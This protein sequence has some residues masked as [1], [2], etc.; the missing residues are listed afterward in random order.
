[1][2]FGMPQVSLQRVNPAEWFDRARTRLNASYAA[3][4]RAWE[5][6]MSAMAVA[7]AALGWGMERVSGG[8]SSVIASVLLTITIGFFVEY[9]GRLLAAHDRRAF[10]RDHIVELVAV[11]PWVRLV[12][13]V[14]L[15]WVV[16]GRAAVQH[17]RAWKT[18]PQLIPAGSRGSR[19]G[20]LWAVLL[21]LTAVA[22]Y[23]YVAAA[24][25]A[26]SEGRFALV[27]MLLC[28]FSGLTASLAT[29]FAARGFFPSEVPSRLRT[30]EELKAAKLITTNEYEAHRASLLGLL[31]SPA[32][33]GPKRAGSVRRVPRPDP[34]A[35]ASGAS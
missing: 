26:G 6:T 11:L 12:R 28:V 33:G 7:F 24:T 35:Q 21:V 10:V 14:R 32:E 22:T 1:M 4:E 17:M 3:H 31:A 23:G 15:L 16:W 30:L 27:V 29:A 18:R 34:A 9:T 8:L 13:P 5:L 20:I 2:T 19:L 25:S